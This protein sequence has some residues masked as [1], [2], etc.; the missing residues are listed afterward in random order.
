MKLVWRRRWFRVAAVVL[1]P[2]IGLYVFQDDVLPLAA[3]FLDVSEQPSNVKYVLVLNGDPDT[4]PFVAAAVYNVG[5]AE[6]VL[7]TTAGPTPK[8]DDG[9]LPP[10]HEIIREVLLK[11]GVAEGNVYLIPGQITSTFDEA[12]ALA[13]FLE[14]HPDGDVAIVTNRFHTRRARWI[15]RRV[16]GDQADRL[17]VFGAPLDDVSEDNWWRTEAGFDTYAKEYAKFAYYLA[18]Y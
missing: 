10:E 4:R 14:S 12:H 18:C 11:R 8:A 5:L 1:L 16:L 2:A 6:K 3:Q 17:H 15:F 7:I 13:R 9:L